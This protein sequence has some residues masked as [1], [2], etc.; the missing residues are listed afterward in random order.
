MQRGD[1]A[2][3]AVQIDLGGFA[4]A[5]LRQRLGATG[6][7][8]QE[9]AA[10]TSLR[11]DAIV[12]KGVKAF[13]ERHA[14]KA[15][16]AVGSATLTALDVPVTVRIDQIRATLERCRWLMHDLSERF[17]LINIAGFMLAVVDHGVPIWE[18]RVVVG[19]PYTQ[20]P[21]FRADMRSIV[22]NPLS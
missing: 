8:P 1:D 9:A 11:Y 3:V 21:S 19:D 10:D 17:I 13:Q 5:I 6:D 7:L 2:A 20:T 4:E 18:T 14:I 12:E 15:D 16:G 22:L